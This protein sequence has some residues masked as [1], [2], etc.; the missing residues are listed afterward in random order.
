MYKFYWELREENVEEIAS[1]V[2]LAEERLEKIEKEQE[3]IIYSEKN[4]A[5]I[6]C[7]YSHVFCDYTSKFH[8]TWCERRS[9]RH[10]CFDWDILNL[11][12]VGMNCMCSVCPEICRSVLAEP[13][14]DV[15]LWLSWC[16][17]NFCYKRS[18]PFSLATV[19]LLECGTYSLKFHLLS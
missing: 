9:R 6:S 17:I 8:C 3:G 12:I 16:Y 15:H 13:G 7:P 19:H 2:W 11:D 4:F 14:K 10:A 18:V 1:H 5:D